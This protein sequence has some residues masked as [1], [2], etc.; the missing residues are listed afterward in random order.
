MADRVSKV[1]RSKIMSKIKS[2]DT[3]LEVNFREILFK[4]GLRFKTYPTNIEGKPDIA[5]PNKKL[6][7][8]VDSCFWH[9]CLKHCRMP[10]TNKTY[11]AAK[12][13]NNVKR[14]EYITNLT[15]PH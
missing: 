3:K 1:E 7:V 15:S 5:F 12:I 4:K 8:F 11:W 2:K 9:G 6:I 13:R 14:D 10:K